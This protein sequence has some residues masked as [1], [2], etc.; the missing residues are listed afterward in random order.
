MVALYLGSIGVVWRME[1]R[2]RRQEDRAPTP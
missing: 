1:R 2:W